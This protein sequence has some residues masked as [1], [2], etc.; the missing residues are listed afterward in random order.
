MDIEDFRRFFNYNRW[1]NQEV[2]AALRGTEPAPSR[3]LRYLAHILAAE[4]LWLER[5]EQRPQT[6][7]VWPDFTVDQ[8]ESH[9][10]ELASL[11]Q[12]F[13]AGESAAGLRNEISY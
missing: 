8:C 1:S 10:R 3:S 9:L 2:L 12:K 5:L 4:R 6:L 13:L 7:P 11:W